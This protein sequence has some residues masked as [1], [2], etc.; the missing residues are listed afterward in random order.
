MASIQHVS[1]EVD[2]GLIATEIA[3]WEL[4]GFERTEPPE[5]IGESAVWMGAGEQAIH[6][7]AVEGAVVPVNGHVALVE[8]D[9]RLVREALGQGGFEVVER[10]PHWGAERLKTTSPAGHLVELMA[11]PPGRAPA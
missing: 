4:L 9:L 3:F 6:L 10:E 1:L 11:A 7:L 8:P 5:G 2:P